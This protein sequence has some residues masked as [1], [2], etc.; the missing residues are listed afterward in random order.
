MLASIHPL[1]ERARNNRWWLTATAFAAASGLGGALTGLTAAMAGA[2]LHPLSRGPIIGAAVAVCALAGAADLAALRIP[3]P[4]RQVNEDWLGTY[5]GWVYG[6]GFGIQLGTGLATIVVSATVPAAFVLAA[7]ASASTVG[8]V[9]G[10][11]DGTSIGLVFGAA[12]AL[13]LL[14]A[15]LIRRWEQ[16]RRFHGRMAGAAGL[17]RLGGAGAAGL[18][19]LGLVVFGFGPGSR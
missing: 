3:S 10:I 15:G 12:R 16:L 6:A 19:V 2:L 11:V 7:L 14:G 5:R 18:T 4:A 13:P 9:S 17:A 8:R 1:G